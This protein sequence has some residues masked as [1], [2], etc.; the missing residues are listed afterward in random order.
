[1]K[2]KKTKK[3]RNAISIN[4]LPTTLSNTQKNSKYISN[5]PKYDSTT[6][7]RQNSKGFNTPTLGSPQ[8]KLS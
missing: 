6:S 7:R 4:S 1:M 3:S 2:M 5:L 8:Q